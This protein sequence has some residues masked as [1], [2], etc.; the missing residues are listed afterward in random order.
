[1][2]QHATDHPQQRALAEDA[3]AQRRDPHG[4][5]PAE[6]SDADEPRAWPSS[7]RHKQETAVARIERGSQRPEGA[8]A[9]PESFAGRQI[10]S[11]VGA[12]LP[13]LGYPPS[14]RALT[15]WFRETYHREPSE[16]EIGVLMGAMAAR[17]GSP[18]REGP[19]PD[20]HGWRT[21]PLSPPTTRR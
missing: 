16:R 21:D 20:Q 4:A 15:A 13:A 5:Q 8:A 10:D 1:M 19:N 7:E 3:E 6:Q 12:E 14:E 11:P 2:A 18:P 17:D 9:T